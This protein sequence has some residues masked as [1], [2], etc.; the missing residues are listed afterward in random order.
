MRQKMVRYDGGFKLIEQSRYIYGG[1]SETQNIEGRMETPAELGGNEPR[2][3][4]HCDDHVAIAVAWPR[5][6]AK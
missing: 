6:F 5:R 3:R 2:P 1:P 4:I